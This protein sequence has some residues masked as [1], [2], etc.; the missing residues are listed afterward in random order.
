MPEGLPP[1]DPKR[2]KALADETRIRILQILD[3]RLSSAPELARE[4]RLSQSLVNYHLQILIECEC[5]ELATTRKRNGRDT[6]FY[7]AKAGAL[8]PAG[9][10]EPDGEP[11][12]EKAMRRF[13]CRAISALETGAAE[14]SMVSTFAIETL[15]LTAP[16]RLSANEALRLTVANLRVLHEL[17]RQLN[18]ATDTPVVPVELA[19]AMFEP[20]PGAA[21]AAI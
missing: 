11:V 10:L 9:R 20:P 8:L 15:T 7:T 4:L 13:A 16:H 14:D 21:G 1:L 18:I 3:H 12:S 5:V 19:I 6:S 2:L 17:S